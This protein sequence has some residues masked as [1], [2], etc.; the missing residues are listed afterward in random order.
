MKE[1]LI[2]FG[3]CHNICFGRIRQV[4]N[5][6]KAATSNTNNGNDNNNNYFY[7]NSNKITIMGCRIVFWQILAFSAY[8][9]H[10]LY[11]GLSSYRY[12]FTTVR[13]VGG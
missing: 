1:Q 3:V 8:F 9:G 2:A 4:I 6:L 5:L 13:S 7:T 11:F 10:A 12:P